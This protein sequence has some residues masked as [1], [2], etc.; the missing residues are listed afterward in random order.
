M[1]SLDLKLI[2]DHTKKGFLREITNAPELVNANNVVNF[3]KISLSH[4]N[5]RRN[6]IPINKGKAILISIISILQNHTFRKMFIDNNFI[7]NLPFDVEEYSDFI[8]DLLELMVTHDYEIFDGKL[9]EKIGQM[10]QFSP[11]KVLVLIAKYGEYMEKIKNPWDTLDLLFF[12]SS[13]FNNPDNALDFIRILTYFCRR[14]EVYN[15]YRSMQCFD[16]I[17]SSFLKSNDINVLKAA[18][19]SLISISSNSEKCK[20]KECLYRFPVQVLLLHLQ[21]KNEEVITCALNFLLVYELTKENI[22]DQL[23]AMNSQRSTIV[24]MKLCE[25]PNNA[26][27]I[28]QNPLYLKKPLPTYLDTLKLIYSLLKHKSIKNILSKSQQIIAFL[29][30]TAKNASQEILVL[31]LGVL[32][33]LTLTQNIISELERKHFFKNIVRS[34]DRCN[35]EQSDQARYNIFEIIADFKYIPEMIDVCKCAITEIIE[36]ESLYSEAFPLIIKFCRFYECVQVMK[37]DGLVDFYTKC[38]NRPKLRKDA[39]LFLDSLPL[40]EEEEEYGEDFNDYYNSDYI[41]SD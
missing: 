27:Y 13:K 24:L 35:G 23:I 37:R 40:F 34:A 32:K 28:A 4:F 29:S 12:H 8:F 30:S 20:S 17:A 36:V 7:Y 6:T 16:V 5:N 11:S 41:Y 15:E 25:N 9:A 22:L 14:K 18:Y 2:E 10:I 3:F 31:I 21:S 39:R 1:S 38:L 33:Q 19:G 26:M